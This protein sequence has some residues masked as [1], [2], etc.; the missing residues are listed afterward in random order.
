MSF[1]ASQ[2]PPMAQP[3]RA[4]RKVAENTPVML[5]P[6]VTGKS[7]EVHV[8]PASEDL[9]Q[10]E[11][12]PPVK[13]HTVS[14]WQAKLPLDAANAASPSDGLGIESHDTRSQC[15]P[16]SW[17]DNSVKQPSVASPNT[18]ARWSSSQTMASKNIALS[19]LW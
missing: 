16:S 7:M 4:F 13:T 3:W 18:K 6:C 5:D 14:P 11:V 17:V 9:R 15:A 12:R 10:R 2:F 1:G 8:A 19:T